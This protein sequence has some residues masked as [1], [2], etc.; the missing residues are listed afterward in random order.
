MGHIYFY[1]FIWCNIEST[2]NDESDWND[3]DIDQQVISVY[4][5]L[6]VPVNSGVSGVCGD[7]AI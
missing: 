2:I 5:D 3:S 1:L 4:C 6:R 7:C